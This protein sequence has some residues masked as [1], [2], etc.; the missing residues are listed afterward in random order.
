M[1]KIDKNK[2]LVMRALL[3]HYNPEDAIAWSATARE[4][5]KQ[6][7]LKENQCLTIGRRL[8]DARLARAI[9]SSKTIKS[10]TSI[11]KKP[12]VGFALNRA[13]AQEFVRIDEQL[14]ELGIN[15]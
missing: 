3:E 4:L 1:Q 6:T 2:F 7:G 15:L 12:I 5:A 9:Q 13:G 14:A 10:G 11:K 8:A